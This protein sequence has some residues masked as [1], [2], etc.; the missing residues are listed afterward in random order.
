[1][2]KGAP[3]SETSGAE[4]AFWTGCSYFSAECRFLISGEV[5]L[6]ENYCSEGTTSLTKALTLVLNIG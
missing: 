6:S 2:K 3:S 5:F 4:L 1:M